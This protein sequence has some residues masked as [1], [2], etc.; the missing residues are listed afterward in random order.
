VIEHR[1]YIYVEP[2]C[3]HYCHG[4]L[5]FLP[6]APVRP[7]G[8]LLVLAADLKAIILVAVPFLGR[9]KLQW[10]GSGPIWRPPAYPERIYQLID[11]ISAGQ[12]N[13]DA[14]DRLSL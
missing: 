4:A 9:I 1:V 3:P 12:K 8:S 5:E 7:N 13:D 10:L 14:A 6:C 11:N 2:V